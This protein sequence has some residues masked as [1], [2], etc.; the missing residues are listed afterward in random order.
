MNKKTIFSFFLGMVVAFLISYFLIVQ[1]AKEYEKTIT[2]FEMAEHTLVISNLSIMLSATEKPLE[3]YIKEYICSRIGLL[4]D[5]LVDRGSFNI[6]IFEIA[7]SQSVENYS[8]RLKEQKE[9][10]DQH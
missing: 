10:C 8:I 3:Q 7:V 2:A 9:R 5:A 4:E 6:D 1:L